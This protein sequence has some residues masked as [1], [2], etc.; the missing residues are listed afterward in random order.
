MYVFAATPA[1]FTKTPIEGIIQDQGFAAQTAIAAILRGTPILVAAAAVAWAVYV[2]RAVVASTVEGQ[3]I[4]SVAERLL[5]V[6]VTMVLGWS[7]L[8][9]QTRSGLVIGPLDSADRTEAWEDLP[10]VAASSQLQR[11]REPSK[12]LWGFA[13]INGAFEEASALLTGAVGVEPDEDPSTMIRT[14]VKLQATTLGEGE[15]GAEVLS[16]FDALARNCGRSDARV[17]HQ[18]GQV[19][20][21]FVTD[22]DPI[23]TDEDGDDIDCAMLWKDFEEASAKAGADLYQAEH[24]EEGPYSGN[25]ALLGTFGWQRAFAL[26]AEFFGLEEDETAQWAINAMIEG[27]LRDAAKRS[28]EGLNPLRKDEATFSE[29]W[30]DYIVDVLVDGPLTELTLNAGAIL[31]PNIHLRAQKAAA[32]ERFNEIADMIPTMRGFLHAA[33]A[34]AFPLCAY[35]LALGWTVPMR[36]WLVGRGV[37]ALYMPVA[38]LLYAM[39]N[40]FAA[41]NGIADNPEFAWLY[42]Q[43]SVVGSLAVLE[44][45]TLRVQTAYLV[46]EVAIFGSFALG[47]AHSLLVGGLLPTGRGA[48]QL[49]AGAGSAAGATMMVMSRFLPKGG[50]KAAASGVRGS[51]SLPSPSVLRV[52]SVTTPLAGSRRPLPPPSSGA[53]LRR[54]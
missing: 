31:D 46:G 41:W 29:G 11:L 36:N 49:A 12:A 28:A 27:T 20:D 37:L 45:E 8:G 5:M 4:G 10:G 25:Q 33:F 21:L 2:Y 13:M 24:P 1:I 30:P 32:A 47:S 42:S 34:V 22:T 16:T 15:S 43:Q 3:H 53:P 14:M 48:K 54:F 19:K 26:G 17:L 9:W 35:A 6:S 38:H 52:G 23:G 44:A 40:Q 39:V 51:M 18:G 7:L 50:A